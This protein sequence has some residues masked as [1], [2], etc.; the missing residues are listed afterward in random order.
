M[1]QV[2]R[3]MGQLLTRLALRTTPCERSGGTDRCPFRERQLRGRRVSKHRKDEGGCSRHD[4]DVH[5]KQAHGTGEPRSACVAAGRVR[6]QGI[7]CNAHWDTHRDTSSCHTRW[8]SSGKG[9]SCCGSAPRCRSSWRTP[10]RSPLRSC[11]RH[12][13]RSR[14]QSRGRGR[15]LRCR[16]RW[17]IHR[18]TPWLRA[19]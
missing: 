3:G 8:S 19:T 11:S 18:S 17:R 1:P 2:V 6:R 10:T 4:R 5:L 9:S 7:A 14:S 16:K 15:P 12:R 13:R